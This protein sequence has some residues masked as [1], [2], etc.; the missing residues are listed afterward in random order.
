MERNTDMDG[1]KIRVLFVSQ[2]KCQINLIGSIYSVFAKGADGGHGLK[3]G[4]LGGKGALVRGVFLW[5]AG[6]TIILLAGQAGINACRSD[7][8]S[9]VS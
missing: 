9:K 2:L 7:L 1:S 5:N 6:D 8:P 3:I 4:A